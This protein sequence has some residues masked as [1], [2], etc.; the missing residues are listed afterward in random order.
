MA[1]KTASQQKSAEPGGIRFV[2]QRTSPVYPALALS[3]FA[4]LLLFLT[5]AVEQTRD[6]LVYAYAAKTGIDL[7]HPHHLLYTPTVRLILLALQPFCA[8]CDAVLAGQIHNILWSIAGIAGFYFLMRRFWPAAA[9]SAALGLLV[10]RGYWELSTQTTMYVPS[11]ALLT[12]AALVLVKIGEDGPAPVHTLLLS[13]LFAAAVLYHQS[14]ILFALP[15][16]VY[17]MPGRWGL[18][19]LATVLALS[20]AAVLGIYILVFLATHETWSLSQFLRFCISYTSE[21]CLGGQC[22]SSPEDWGSLDNLSP[23]GLNL[24][25][26]SLL[27]NLI[28]VPEAIE[29]FVL[30]LFGQ[31][32]LAFTGWHVLQLLRRAESAKVRVFA[33]V[34]VLTYTLFFLW[35]LPSYQHPFVVILPPAV[36]LVALSVRDIL[37]RPSTVSR[38]AYLAAALALFVVLVTG[39]RNLQA[40]ILPLHRSPG[41]SYMEAVALN[42]LAAP[43]CTIFTSY[44]TWNHLRYYFDRTNA[45]QAKHPMS[46]FYSQ[47]P[48]PATYQLL[49][50][51]C[52][53]AA[54]MFVLPS[55]VHDDFSGGGLDGYQAPAAWLTYISWLFDFDYS[56][57]KVTSSRDF[58]AVQLS[59]G[60][61]YLILLPNRQPVDGL[62]T[63]FHRLDSELKDP[64]RPFDSW[65]SSQDITL[66]P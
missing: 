56:E 6:S 50:G 48:L 41:D 35:W 19:T 14:N 13:A 25:I 16:A 53:Y 37:G 26:S 59:G 47:E 33:L 46:Y 55:F 4:F 49:P 43:D 58:S 11:A 39:G 44:R 61:T 5:R 1:T 62:D 32:F 30:P 63:L 7:F 57:Q 2:L 54:A 23:T 65:L 28:V 52:V 3:T 20:G 21:V 40:R 22:K 45:V 10:T 18:R 29:R 51:S 42:S 24:L 31:S 36:L 9:L 34:W 12:L 15:L 60:E 66:A 38:R 17:L 64:A 8:S 27:W